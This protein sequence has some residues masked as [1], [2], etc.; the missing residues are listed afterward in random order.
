MIDH[1]MGTSA[2]GV[3]LYPREILPSEWTWND[4][5]D[6]WSR[7]GSVIPYD[8]RRS[9][10]VPQQIYSRN[11]DVGAYQLLSLEMK[12]MEDISGIGSIL[13]GKEVAANMSANLYQMQAQNASVSLVDMF[14]SFD[15]FRRE[16]DRKI[17]GC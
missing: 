11:S 5:A 15:M 9:N 16:R 4:I 3:L 10:A 8:S 14:A 17:L 1:I 12:M 6:A 13:Q 2:K 7:S